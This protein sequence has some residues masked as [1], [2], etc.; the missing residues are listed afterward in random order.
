VIVDPPQNILGAVYFFAARFFFSGVPQFSYYLWTFKIQ[1][2]Y[3]HVTYCQCIVSTYGDSVLSSPNNNWN[4]FS[5]LSSTSHINVHVEWI[6]F[7][8]IFFYVFIFKSFKFIYFL[9][10]LNYIP[11]T[12]M[13][14]MLLIKFNICLFHH[15]TSIPI[16]K[17][18]TRLKNLY[19]VT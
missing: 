14:I 11:W 8:V 18:W 13:L 10:F 5:C 1:S 12:L 9:C 17:I 19:S 15:H 16:M 6:F 3:F 4:Q 2:K 7:P